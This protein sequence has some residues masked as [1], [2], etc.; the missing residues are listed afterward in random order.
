MTVAR[1][2]LG[3]RVFVLADEFGV[4]IGAW[5]VVAR[6]RRLDEGAWVQLDARH[7]RCPF[8]ASDARSAWILTYPEHCSSDQPGAP[9]S[10]KEPGT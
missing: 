1:L 2:I 10:P 5:G 6:E 3:Q 8:A 7:A 9:S 4:E